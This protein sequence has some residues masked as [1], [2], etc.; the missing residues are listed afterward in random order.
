MS[1]IQMIFSHLALGVNIAFTTKVGYAH[2]D[3]IPSQS[4]IQSSMVSIKT[5]F[6]P[7]LLDLTF[8]I[9][10]DNSQFHMVVTFYTK[11]SKS[12]TQKNGV[13]CFVSVS[14]ISWVVHILLH[15]NDKQVGIYHHATLKSSICVAKLIIISKYCITITLI[16]ITF[17][18]KIITSLY[19]IMYK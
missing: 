11:I 5:P 9:V 6:Q 7:F 8:I 14:S 3:M 13:V 19:N 4:Y 1:I 18:C 16:L 2:R 10:R 17:S 15:T 12:E